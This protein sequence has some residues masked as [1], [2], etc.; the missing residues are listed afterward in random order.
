MIFKSASKRQ[1]GLTLLEMMVVLLIASM[2][3][4]L[5]FQSL[6]QWQR[7][8]TAI[9]NISGATQQASLTESW[10]QNSLR[11]LIPLE[12]APFDG[13]ENHLRGVTV[14]P[15]QSHQGGATNIQ[16]ALREEDGIWQLHLDEDGVQLSLP[17]PGTT[18]LRFNYLDGD[19]RL[20]AQWPPKLGLHDHLP[21][22][23]VLRQEMEDG[24]VRLW[25]STIAGAHNPR[26]N[27]FEVDLD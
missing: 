4:T 22:T 17:L 14:Q 1:R 16:W 2:A 12:E 20:Y 3:I 25:A 7:A 19:G 8:N 24:S 21:A 13:A 23:I 11:S 27:P 6:G 26:F 18:N 9:S 5:G 15:V 10:L